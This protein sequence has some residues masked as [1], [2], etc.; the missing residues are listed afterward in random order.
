MRRALARPPFPRLALEVFAGTVRDAAPVAVCELRE[1]RDRVVACN[2]AAVAGAVRAGMGT[3]EAQACLP[4]MKL[5]SRAP[6]REREALER[7]AM[8]AGAF[9]DQVGLFPPREVVLEAG[10]SLRLFGGLE[11][12]EREIGEAMSALGREARIGVAPTPSAARLLARRGGGGLAADADLERALADWPCDVLDA[13]DGAAARLQGWGLRTLGEVMRLPRAGLVRRLGRDCVDRLDRLLGRRPEPVERYRPPGRFDARLSLPDETRELDLPLQAL[14]QLVRELALFL[15]ARDAAVQQL[16]IRLHGR[17]EDCAMNVGLAVPGREAA[18]L[19]ELVRE[20]LERTGP[21]QPVTAVS[22]VAPRLLAH[23]PTAADLWHDGERHEPPE[24]LLERLRARLGEE[25][26]RGLS[27]AADHRP[28]RAWHWQ[29]PGRAPSHEPLR[30][31]PRPLWLLPQ[32]AA[33][34]LD[35]SRRP[36][37]EGELELLDGPERIETGWWDG[38]DVERDYFV[39]R[40]PAGMTLWVYRERRVPRT[41]Y[42]HGLFG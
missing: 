31:L 24:R 42:L 15:R 1:G 28:E 12:L 18:H 22:L 25:A 13:G 10:G 6:A 29:P 35:A 23:A 4:I 3:A 34:A 11:N 33:L 19:F 36:R 32:P 38:D 21:T 7:A 39:A 20:R 40:N 26:V 17:G 2:P 9:S 37:F 16:A 41:W 14:E 8:G 30:P 5:L 27:L